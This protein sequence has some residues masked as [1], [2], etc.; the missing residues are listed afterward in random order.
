[1]DHVEQAR[2]PRLVNRWPFH[3]NCLHIL[4]PWMKGL[5]DARS[6]PDALPGQEYA[7]ASAVI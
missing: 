1:V 4:L 5:I 7:T 3:P 2:Y 6:A